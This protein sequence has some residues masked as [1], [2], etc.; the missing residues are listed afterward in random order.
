MRSLWDTSPRRPRSVPRP[1]PLRYTVLHRV[2][3]PR[4]M[5]P[6]SVRLHPETRA[7]SRS[8]STRTSTYVLGGQRELP[9]W[10]FVPSCQ[11]VQHAP[12]TWAAGVFP[13]GC[14]YIRS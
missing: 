13:K 6:A 10:G 11:A 8:P 5:H 4:P 9:G 1:S 2:C 12:V 14:K 3:F 7:Q